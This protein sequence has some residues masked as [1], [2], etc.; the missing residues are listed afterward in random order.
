MPLTQKDSKR[1]SSIKPKA[2]SKFLC[3]ALPLRRYNLV[4][5][6][7]VITFK[8]EIKWKS[9]NETTIMTFKNKTNQN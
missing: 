1:H 9:Q 4:L 2:N 7:H 5:L 6:H 3:P 8:Q